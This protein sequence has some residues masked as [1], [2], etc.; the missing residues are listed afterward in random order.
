LSE[1]GIFVSV[2]IEDA[3]ILVHF[4]LA[5]QIQ[6]VALKCQEWKISVKLGKQM[7]SWKNPNQN[8]PCKKKC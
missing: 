2:W 3:F 1:K 7:V 6:K 8:P 4:F 5:V